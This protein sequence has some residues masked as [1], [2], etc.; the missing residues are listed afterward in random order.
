MLDELN[1]VQRPP[2]DEQIFDIY[3]DFDLDPTDDSGMELKDLELDT[4]EQLLKWFKYQL[5][6]VSSM[7]TYE[8]IEH[9]YY[10]RCG[11]VSWY[12]M[13][14]DWQTVPMDDY[15]AAM[16]DASFWREDNGS[17]EY[18]HSL[19]DLSAWN[20]EYYIER[21][22]VWHKEKQEWVDNDNWFDQLFGA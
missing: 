4:A 13:V 11:D 14:L 3:T 9:Y 21:F 15:K 1:G 5:E 8:L 12:S 18:G 16:D 17:K 7:I 10:D 22:M 6:K 19:D 20:N 2:I